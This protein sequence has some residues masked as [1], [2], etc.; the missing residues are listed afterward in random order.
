M[1]KKGKKKTKQKGLA[2]KNF[3]NFIKEAKRS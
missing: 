1:K 3:K 2:T